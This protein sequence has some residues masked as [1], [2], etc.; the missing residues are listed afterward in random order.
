MPNPFRKR[1]S[2]AAPPAPLAVPPLSTPELPAP[3]AVEPPEEH[4]KAAYLAIAT[5]MGSPREVVRKVQEE[6]GVSADEAKLAVDVARSRMGT[7]LADENA[8]DVLMFQSLHQIREMRNRFAQVALSP[9][10]EQTVEI[11][12]P[13][14]EDPLKGASFRPVTI[15]EQAAQMKMRTDA[16]KTSI[17]AS[18][19]LRAIIGKKVNSWADKP[20]TAVQVNVGLSSEDEEL[21]RRLRMRVD[22]GGRA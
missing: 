5:C 6:I 20:S 8:A 11:L 16:A 22:V 18:D 7:L 17:A 12:G 19:T 14:P 1:P 2:T 4:L 3:A 10:A 9:V 21:M 15:G 13:D